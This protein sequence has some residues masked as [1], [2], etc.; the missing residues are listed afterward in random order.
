[1]LKA[2]S[3]K[4]NRGLTED[5]VKSIPFHCW[6]GKIDTNRLHFKVISAPRRRGTN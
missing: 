2:T 5:D 3:A 1:L 4:K 6:A